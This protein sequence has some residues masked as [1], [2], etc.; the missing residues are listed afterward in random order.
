M[1]KNSSAPR[2]TPAC[3]QHLNANTRLVSDQN[4][5]DFMSTRFFTNHGVQTLFIE[6]ASSKRIQVRAHPS[7][8]LHAKIYI[9]RPQ[10]FNEHRPGAVITG[11]S[12]LTEAGLGV[13]GST[14]TCSGSMG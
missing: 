9:F 1:L 7:K 14:G 5:E 4:P 11:S 13:R 12:N 10:G 6:D 8:N 2:P 3:Q